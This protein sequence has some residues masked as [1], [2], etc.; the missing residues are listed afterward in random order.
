M[1]H[2]AAKFRRSGF[3]PYRAR[4]CRALAVVLALAALVPFEAVA[5]DGRVK[6]VVLDITKQHNIDEGLALAISDLVQGTISEDKSRLVLGREDIR[7]VLSFEQEK[8]ALGC[9]DASCLSEIASALDVDRMIT[10]SIDKVG[11]S[12]L[13]DLT[14]RRPAP[15]DS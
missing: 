3:S 10:G 5:Q 13:R 14:E 9:D 11:T 1:L 4:M 7:R 6:T 15:A 8:A 12:Y 2:R